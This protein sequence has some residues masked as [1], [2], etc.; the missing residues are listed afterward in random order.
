V[1]ATQSEISGRVDRPN[2]DA[3]S[4]IAGVLRNAYI[5][6]LRTGFDPTHSPP[7]PTDTVTTPSSLTTAKEAEEP[8]PAAKN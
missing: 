1:I 8:S 2:I 4:A 6:A 5:E 7:K 3:L